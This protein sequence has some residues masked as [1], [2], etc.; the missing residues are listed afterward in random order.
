VALSLQFVWPDATEV[1]PILLALVAALS[2]YLV[3]H[4]LGG[5]TEGW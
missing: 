3:G 1:P 4:F 2:A 5:L